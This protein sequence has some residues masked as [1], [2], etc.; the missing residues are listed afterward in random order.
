VSISH[1]LNLELG[2][3]TAI[4]NVA[5]RSLMATHAPGIDP[6]LSKSRFLALREEN[7]LW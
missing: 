5:K 7:H 2:A 4:G 1:A 3:V 6:N